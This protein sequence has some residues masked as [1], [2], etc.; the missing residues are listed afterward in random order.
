MKTSPQIVW[1]I[2]TGVVAVVAGVVILG[3]TGHDTGNLLS[4]A[5]VIIAT[6]N[7]AFTAIVNGKVD[8]VIGQTDGSNDRLLSMVERSNPAITPAAETV[9]SA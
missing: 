8:R 3:A 1:A 7:G 6:A 9:T 5:S 4:L 2:V